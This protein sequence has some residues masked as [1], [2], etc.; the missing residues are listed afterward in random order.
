[1]TA[2]LA[3][4][5]GQKSHSQSKMILTQADPKNIPDAQL[6]DSNLSQIENQSDIS[7]QRL[8]CLL[9]SD[10]LNNIPIHPMRFLRKRKSYWPIFLMNLL[11]RRSGLSAKNMF[12]PPKASLL[13]GKD[14]EPKSHSEKNKVPISHAG[15]IR[16][17]SEIGIEADPGQP[18]YILSKTEVFHEA[19]ALSGYLIT[20]VV[21][22]FIFPEMK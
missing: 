11:V 18:A 13:V 21:K 5:N 20:K 19:S 3:G 6:A 10:Q 16:Y 17:E 4:Q 8:L 1:M 9:V 2:N 12:T 15:G 22:I 14:T 7:S